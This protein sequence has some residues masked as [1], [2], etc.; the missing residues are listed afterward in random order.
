M[1]VIV[2]ITK[3]KL[4]QLIVKPPILFF[5]AAPVGNCYNG[6]M[7]RLFLL[8][9]LTLIPLSLC[10]Q[11][12]VVLSPSSLVLTE[13]EDS[14]LF[15]E[16]SRV[17]VENGGVTAVTLRLIPS[18]PEIGV[19]P[20][21]I[22]LAPGESAS[23]FLS[24]RGEIPPAGERVFP[25]ILLA[26]GGTAPAR[27]MIYSP[28]DY[29]P[30][31]PETGKEGTADIRLAYYYSPS[32]RD[33][34]E[35]LA[36]EIPRLEER[37]GLDIAMTALNVFEEANMT[38]LR[39]RLSEAGRETDALPV[40]DTGE[41]ILAGDREIR[42]SLEDV[43]T[44]SAPS[45]LSRS[46][47]AMPLGLMVAG[48]G[49]LDGINPCA[50]STLIFLLAYLGLRKGSRREILLVGIFFTVSVFLT[51]TA[52]GA[53]AFLFLRRS[54]G[55][56]RV[57]FL[58]RW[59]GAA[60][61]SILGILSL[62]DSFKARR[63]DASDMALQLS[64]KMKKAVHKS[65]RTGVRSSLPLAGACLMGFLV[66]IYELGCTGQIYLPTL[67]L[68]IRRGEEE[69][70]A[71]LILYNLAFILPLA[72]VFFLAYRGLTSERLGAYFRERLALIKLITAL[73]FWG[74]ALLILLI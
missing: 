18:R 16:G 3:L 31:P 26:S 63:G 39:E 68:M 62:R 11:T 14:P 22:P 58:L 27:F 15:S 55:F 74:A 45:E 10:G 2:M 48:A 35:F 36:T 30:S 46:R 72:G 32:C 57:S 40:L 25:L 60:V 49:L 24:W 37:L 6:A 1:I 41:V 9:I 43:L 44:G 20:Q 53:G 42:D 52:V 23:V 54:L 47:S 50:F 70:I 17:T 38:R 21:E 5:I 4:L 12:D 73:F 8:L 34:R 64:E 28:R 66:T 19:N 65:V 29:Q 33:C 51:Y 59:G 56:G 69:G 67:Y 61:L 71:L 13:E 7:P